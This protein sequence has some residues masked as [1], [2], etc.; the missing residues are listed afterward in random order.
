MDKFEVQK[1]VFTQDG[2]NLD[3]EQF[4]WDEKAKVF[5][6]NISLLKF[7]FKGI[8]NI[9]FIANNR[10]HFEAGDGCIFDV[11]CD[12]FGCTDE[13]SIEFPDIPSDKVLKFNKN[14]E[15]GYDVI[16]KNTVEYF[17]NK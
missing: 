17:K 1:K 3:L 2:K 6:T 12:C 13:Y 14:S 7:N 10:S 9:I 5:Q 11:D 8:K 16:D 4:S 15:L